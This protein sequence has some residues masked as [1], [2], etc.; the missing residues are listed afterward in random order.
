MASRSRSDL[1]REAFDQLVG[2]PGGGGVVHNVDTDEVSTSVSKGQESEEQVKG[3]GGDGEEVDGDN[4]AGNQR[5][6]IA[7]LASLRTNWNIRAA[8][9]RRTQ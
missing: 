8:I 5:M 7:S 1:F 4:L 6:M 9:R 3:E 2:G